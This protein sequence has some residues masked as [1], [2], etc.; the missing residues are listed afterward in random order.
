MPPPVPTSTL[1]HVNSTTTDLSASSDGPPIRRRYR[2]FWNA[3]KLFFNLSTASP[4]PPTLCS[5]A[6][7]PSHAWFERFLVSCNAASILS[8]REPTLMSRHMESAFEFAAEPKSHLL[9]SSLDVQLSLCP[10]GMVGTTACWLVMSVSCVGK[11]SERNPLHCSS[12]QSS[13]PLMSCMSGSMMVLGWETWATCCWPG[14]WNHGTWQ[15]Q[16]RMFWSPES[17]WHAS[18]IQAP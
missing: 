13:H 14:D 6:R 9:M 10:S 1:H 12:H 2:H 3:L 8:S 18:Q 5:S 7:R 4:T 15:P 16:S 17:R 11:V